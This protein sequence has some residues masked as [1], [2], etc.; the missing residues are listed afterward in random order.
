MET[1]DSDIEILTPENII[2]KANEITLN[3]LPQ[4]SKELYL[5]EYETFKEWRLKNGVQSFS[6]KVL[7]VYFDEKSKQFKPSTLWS[8]Y[9]KLKATLSIN[10]DI[11]ISKYV[12]LIAFL[13]H[14][15]VG[16][17]PKKSRTFSRE[18]ITKFILEA[19]DDKYLMNKVKDI[20][21]NTVNCY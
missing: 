17:K 1:E 13:K 4:K 19:P 20:S 3:L 5:K 6:E 8:T 11:D 15:S 14:Q 16:Y 10:Q 2:E 21:D 18:E 9:S 7:L 12:K